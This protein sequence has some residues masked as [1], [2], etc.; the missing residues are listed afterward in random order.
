MKPFAGGG[1]VLHTVPPVVMPVH[2]KTRSSIF[3][4]RTRTRKATSQ[5]KGVS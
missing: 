3:E 5:I 1:L 4:L 2:S